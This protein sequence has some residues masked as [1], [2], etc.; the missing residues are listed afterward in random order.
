M[1][2]QLRI[3]FMY[4]NFICLTLIKTAQHV[5]QKSDIRLSIRLFPEIDLCLSE[6]CQNGGYCGRTNSEPGVTC[7]C[8]EGFEGDHCEN[9]K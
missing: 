6:P 4:Q 1:P 2:S 8:P 5:R 7:A 3:N 9:S